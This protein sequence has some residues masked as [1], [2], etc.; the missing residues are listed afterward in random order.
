MTSCS[1]KDRVRLV[2]LYALRFE[3]GERERIAALLDFLVQAGVRAVSPDLYAAAES[4]L[5]YGGKDASV[6]GVGPCCLLHVTWDNA[7][8]PGLHH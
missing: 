2:M 4:I 1:N 8:E 5:R 6:P 7:V 3:G